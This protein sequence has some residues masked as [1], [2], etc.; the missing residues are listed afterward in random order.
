MERQLVSSNELVKLVNQRVRQRANIDDCAV[1]GV[2][3]L[4]KPGDDGCNWEEIGVKG[5]HTQG[6][7]L[8][9]R[10]LRAAYNLEDDL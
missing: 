2:V 9:V 4:H 8:A 10:E 7:R 3:R 6:F 1:A 5:T